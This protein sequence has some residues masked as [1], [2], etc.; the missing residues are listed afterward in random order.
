MKLFTG[1]ITL[2]LFLLSWWPSVWVVSPDGNPV[3]SP[4]APPDSGKPDT[5]QLVWPFQDQGTIPG[6]ETPYNSGMYLHLPENIRED[7]EYNPETNEY[8]VSQKAGEVEYRPTQHFSFDEYLQ[9]DA[10]RSLNSYWRQRFRSENFQHQSSLIPT[11]HIGGDAFESIFGSNVIDI[12]PQGSAELIFGVQINRTDNPQLPEKMR[13]TTTFDFQEKIQMNVTGQIGDKL[14]IAT[15]YNTEA[16]FEFEN[17]MNLVYEGKED[18]IIRKIEAGNVSLPL[19]GSLITG[20]Q[21]LFGIKTE[22]QF[23]R[24]NVTTVFSQQKGKSQVVEVQ[25]GAQVSEYEVWADQYE[26]N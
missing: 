10:R 15:N 26:A 22:L 20:S 3:T 5:T 25:G 9:Y 17:K 16:S 6:E 13:K 7:V 19:S 23:G 2:L 12:K 11:L 18:E 8:S 4:I 14:K 21:S 1:N 24:L